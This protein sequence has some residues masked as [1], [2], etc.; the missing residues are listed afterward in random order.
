MSLRRTIALGIAGLV[1]VTVLLGW[2]V[3]GGAILKPFARQVFEHHVKTAVH[4]AE[5]VEG[6][7]DPERLA[8]RMGVRIHV[9][10]GPPPG[11]Q[12]NPEAWVREE[13]LGHNVVFRPGPR[14][15]VG[16]ETTVGW[17][18]IAHELDL[19]R[20]WRRMGLFLVLIGLGVFGVAHLL[21]RRTLAP[22]ETTRDAMERMA[23]GELDHRLADEGPT[24]LRQAAEAFNTMADRVDAMLRTER[25]LM[26]GISHELRTPLTRLQLELA[27]LEDAEP[28]RATAMRADLDELSALL[29]E[30]LSISKMQLG[31]VQISNDEVDLGAIADDLGLERSGEPL[32]LRGDA[33]LLRRALDNLARNTRRY[34]GG[35]PSVAFDGRLVHV[36]DRLVHV[37]DHGPGVADEA[38]DKLFEPFFRA[39]ASRDRKTGGSGLGLMI[40]RQVVELH[41]GRVRAANR[42]EG[43]L[44]VTLDFAG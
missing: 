41:G 43:G 25:E 42:A 34:A 23:A 33:T 11:P 29:T 14:N 44:R 2:L 3:A 5:E 6:G 4:I 36:D 28:E 38:L 10:P 17:V 7:E 1:G 27:L 37:D 19:E 20:P 21:V 18:V 31:Q 35:P 24:E 13:V 30:M 32:I 26:A 22:L 9:A 15:V 8:E 39:E 16:V 12:G 40:V